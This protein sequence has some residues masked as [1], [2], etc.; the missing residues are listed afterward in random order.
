MLFVKRKDIVMSESKKGQ[1]KPWRGFEGKVGGKWEKAK[2][3]EDTEKQHKFSELAQFE[4]NKG[5]GTKD[6]KDF[7]EVSSKGKVNRFFK[8]KKKKKKNRVDTTKLKSATNEVEKS[9][10]GVFYR[11]KTDA[12]D[13]SPK[14][15]TSVIKYYDQKHIN[16]IKVAYQYL[17][18]P[19]AIHS[20]IHALSLAAKGEI[21][22]FGK[23]KEIK[24]GKKYAFNHEYQFRVQELKIFEQF[25]SAAHTSMDDESLTKWYLGLVEAGE[26]PALWNLWWH[27]HGTMSTFF[28]GTDTDTLERLSEAGSKVIGL[29]SNRTGSLDASLYM[30]GNCVEEEL[31]VRIEPFIPDAM[32]NDIKKEVKR[33]VTKGYGYI[34]KNAG[35]EELEEDEY[36]YFN[37]G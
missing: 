2:E 8:G 32:K 18:L 7:P 27:S 10:G 5:N 17:V 30:N 4:A 29:C 16:R 24:V 37:L 23:I 13:K 35:Y 12:D 14:G 11:K 33:F 26:D 21:S 28:S 3:K 9:P 20:R 22:G 15:I 1:N 34:H 25:G 31:E 36:D 6:R 19:A